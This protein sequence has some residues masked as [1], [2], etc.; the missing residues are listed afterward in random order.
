MKESRRSDWNHPI[1]YKPAISNA[2]KENKQKDEYENR[3]Q[4]NQK[5]KAK[6]KN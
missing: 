2:S 5:S 3:V 4:R 6:E 1:N